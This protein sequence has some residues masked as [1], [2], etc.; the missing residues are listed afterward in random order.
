MILF[1]DPG[2]SSQAVVVPAAPAARETSLSQQ[3]QRTK[4]SQ[5]VTN[6]WSTHQNNLAALHTTKDISR[7][8]TKLELGSRVMKNTEAQRN[9]PAG[10][11]SNNEE[12]SSDGRANNGLDS[13][14][15]RDNFGRSCCKTNEEINI[16]L[17]ADKS[18]L[19]LELNNVIQ[20]LGQKEV[21]LD[22]KVEE[23]KKSH[24]LSML[25]MRD[26]LSRQKRLGDRCKSEME[27]LTK[28]FEEKSRTLKG[29]T[30]NLNDE[31]EELK[32]ENRSLRE[33]I[34]QLR[35]ELEDKTVEAYE[36]KE[37]NGIYSAKLTKLERKF[38]KLRDEDEESYM[39]M[40]F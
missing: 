25:E 13:G 18:S 30:D 4:S 27:I 3:E 40:T 26:L 24:R 28:T 29:K 1:D 22:L 20:K 19:Q 31:N 32:E 7:G 23:L 21:E 38:K 5:P 17:M 33:E 16:R 34:Q 2:L 35:A 15:E 37:M 8:L 36:A 39:E 11:A 10:P 6:V 9:S 12:P 14:R